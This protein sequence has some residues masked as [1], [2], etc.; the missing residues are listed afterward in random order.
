MKLY[1]AIGLLSLLSKTSALSLKHEYTMEDYEGVLNEF[2]PGFDSNNDEK[3]TQQELK[4]EGA[5]P[6]LQE[7]LNFQYDT[8]K[9]GE[10]TFDEIRAEIGK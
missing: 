9:D 10:I 1:L 6:R 4:D 3:I 7:V 8:N 5:T 2:L